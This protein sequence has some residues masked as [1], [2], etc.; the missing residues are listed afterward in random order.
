[1]LAGNYQ[2][3]CWSLWVKIVESNAKLVLENTDRR[4]LA[5]YDLAENAAWFRHCVVMKIKSQAGGNC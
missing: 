2:D 4:D 3:M 5:R 1:M